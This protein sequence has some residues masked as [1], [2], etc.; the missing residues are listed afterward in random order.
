MES[1]TTENIA[2]ELLHSAGITVNGHQPWDIIVHDERFYQ[3]ALTENALG[4][5]ESYMENWWDCPRIDMFFDRVLTAHL[6]NKIKKNTRLLFKFLIFK[7]VNL[8]TKR[9]ALDVGKKHYDIGNVLF[10]KMLDSR[11]NYTCGYW[12][13]AQNLDEAQLAKLELTCQKLALK[14]GMRLLDIGCGWGALAKYAAE[15]YGVS[16]VGVTISEQQRDYAQ[17]NCAGLPVDIRFQ[18]YRDVKEKFDRISSLGMFEHVGHQNYETYMKIVHDCLKDDGLFLLHTIG[19]NLTSVPNEW[20]TKY[21]FPNGMLPSI[22]LI[23]KSIEGLFVMEDWHN[24]GADYDKTLMA[25]QHNFATH[26]NELKNEY[27][28]RFYRMWNYYLLSCAGGFRSRTV[29]LWQIV[30][31]KGGRKGGYLAPR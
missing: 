4:L 6:E 12:K 3:R 20:I 10:E 27:D 23:G 11:M 7:L 15:K 9:R 25:W 28:D 29:Q 22:T 19:D 31:S 14:P 30:L 13:N 16:V 18:D 1:K 21:I 8:Q 5:G 24:F 17:K 26:W 2:A